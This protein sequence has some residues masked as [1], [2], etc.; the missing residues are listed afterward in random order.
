MYVFVLVPMSM[1]MFWG[2]KA[3]VCRHAGPWGS[4][5]VCHSDLI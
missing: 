3:R 1:N 5:V 4:H 2:G